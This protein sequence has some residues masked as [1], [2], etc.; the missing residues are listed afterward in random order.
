VYNLTLVPIAAGVF[1]PNFGFALPPMLAGAAMALSSVSIVVSSL[2]LFLYKP[3]VVDGGVEKK[4]KA[5]NDAKFNFKNE[6]N[7]FTLFILIFFLL[8]IIFFY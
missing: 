4:M 1:Y 6:G 7:K 2:L 8:F 5:F 3:P